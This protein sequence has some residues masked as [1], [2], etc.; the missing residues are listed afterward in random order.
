MSSNLNNAL[1]VQDQLLPGV[2]RT[3]ALTIPQLPDGLREPITNAYLL[4]RIAD[5]I[6]DD[7]QLQREQKAEFHD[8]FIRVV[9]GQE[10][11]EPFARELAPLLSPETLADEVTLIEQT[12]TVITVTQSFNDRQRAALTRC[13]RIMCHG[14][15]QYQA[16]KSIAGLP[17]VADMDRYCYYV[18][19]VVGEMLTELFCDYSESIASHRSSM[20]PLAV[21]F[22]QGLQMTN[23]LKDFWEDRAAAACWLPQ[24]LFHSHGLNLADADSP[25]FQNRF[26]KGIEDLLGMAHAY[27]RDALGYVHLIPS[28]ETG[29]RRFCLWAIGLAVHTL[30]SIRRHPEYRAGDAVKISRSAVRRILLIS[31][32]C[33]RS[34]RLLRFGFKMLA[35]GLPLKA[36]LMRSN[37]AWA[38]PR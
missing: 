18:A 21:A 33:S 36:E 1:S 32:L 26:E 31:N 27:L 3:F 25:A 19:G 15:P 6:E 8:R 17:T 11:P 29:I 16:E 22:G 9:E 38:T 23:I 2:S 30:Q 12:A 35:R 10:N 7:V 28:S 37:Q 13:I 34:N 4:C 20:M 24:E 14:M 5:T